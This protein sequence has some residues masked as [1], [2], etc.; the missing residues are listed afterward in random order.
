MPRTMPLRT[1]A[2]VLRQRGIGD[3]DK[4]CVLLSPG[5]GRIE[6]V[7][8]GVRKTTSRLAGHVDALSRGTFQLA[9]GRSMLI[10]TQA[11]T[12]DA[13]PELHD[14]MDRLSL[15]SGVAELIDRTAMADV[16][17][18]QLYRLVRE[19]LSRVAEAPDARAAVRWF[20]L[21]WL[22][23][24]G[25]QPELDDC[26]RC[27]TPL[28]PT[29]NGLAA[30]DG[31]VVCPDCHR[32]GAGLPLSPAA[33]KLLRYMRRSSF[34]HS[35]QVRLDRATALEV[36]RQLASL[37]EHALDGRLRS[38][39][40]AQALEGAERRAGTIPTATREANHAPI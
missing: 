16:H 28:G 22:D 26:V 19:T 10:V 5:R 25:Y 37:V 8:R 27:R 38:A 15:A 30:G 32:A 1:E 9:Q 3:A 40:F 34:E 36:D 35:A 33:F 14:D 23:Q 7:A 21:H 6:A 17:S 24:Q 11:Q 12:L 2:I 31:G 13:W 29:G 39:S 4:V 20:Q 18:A